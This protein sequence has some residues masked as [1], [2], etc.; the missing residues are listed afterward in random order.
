MKKQLAILLSALMLTACASDSSSDGRTESGGSSPSGQNESVNSTEEYVKNEN[1]YA[2]LPDGVR[3]D[4]EQHVR[5]VTIDGEGYIDLPRYGF[6]YAAPGGTQTFLYDAFAAGANADNNVNCSDSA[7]IV[8]SFFPD[9]CEHIRLSNGTDIYP[10]CLTREE[11]NNRVQAMYQMEEEQFYD[12]MKQELQLHIPFIEAHENSYFYDYVGVS[13]PAESETDEN[14]Q[15]PTLP[16]GTYYL[17]NFALTYR[18]RKQPAPDSERTNLKSEFIERGDNCFG[19]KI[20]YD[21]KRYGL[22]MTKHVYWLYNRG[23]ISLHRIE[24]TYDK[25][26]EPQLDEDVFLDALEM[27]DPAPL[28]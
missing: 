26:T 25:R 24:F 16:P 4:D 6:R 8:T 27:Y 1:P 13:Q 22:D 2:F 20:S 3:L 17:I 10:V 18:N 12:Q 5:E 28:T 21:Q 9:S 23:G 19:V 14:W 7:F 11:F 15:Q